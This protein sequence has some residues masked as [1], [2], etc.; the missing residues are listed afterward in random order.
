MQVSSISIFPWDFRTIDMSEA[1]YPEKS[2]E[3]GR[4]SEVVFLPPRAKTRCRFAGTGA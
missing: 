2:P 1:S 4:I 3:P